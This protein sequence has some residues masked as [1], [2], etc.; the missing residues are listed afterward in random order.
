MTRG[1]FW[2]RRD[3][4]VADNP[5]L[6]KA[7]ADCD[8]LLLLYID[9][10][11]VESRW[12]E[13]AASRWWLQS[14]LTSLAMELHRRGTRL[15]FRRGAAPEILSQ[16]VGWMDAG[17]VYWN[18]LYEP[19]ALRTEKAVIDDLRR[20]GCG[21]VSG[22]ANLLTTPES[23]GKSD[24]TPYRVFSPFWRARQRAGFDL[25]ECTAPARLPPAPNVTGDPI[26]VQPPGRWSEKFKAYWEPGEASAR[27]RLQRFINGELGG[28]PNSRDRPA[29][30]GTSRLSPHL[31][32]GEIGPRQILSAVTAWAAETGRDAAAET[33]IRQLGWREF[34]HHLLCHF[35]QTP[36]RPLDQRFEHFRWNDD[37]L[38]SLLAWQ[39]AETGFPIIDA[40]LRELW[41]TG[42]MHN[43]VRLIA[44]SFLTK[45]LL[46]PWQEGARWFWDTLLD[47]DL[48]NNTLGWQW[49]AGSGADAA[50]WFRIF[51][52]VLQAER[53]DPEG[54]YV[55]RWLP[56]LQSLQGRKIHQP[57]RSD[58]PPADYPPPMVDLKAT[59]ERALLRYRQL[60]KRGRP[61]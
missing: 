22:D 35:P 46:V 54:G 38:E 44:A 50:P 56:E 12:P 39:R 55:R 20:L 14:S 45:N 41:E 52:P 58:R 8:E 26:D 48:A 4:R 3:L 29:R 23:S 17:W 43:R 6:A 34:A 31:H 30:T 1:I 11:A 15:V 42:W 36:D 16:L 32:F 49:V 10:P 7:A 25:G 53:F 13:G 33:F 60:P 40:G 47:A 27:R 59:R 21:L 2:F 9:E 28:Y 19:A 51:N 37:Y 5:L 18:R 57:W 61:R 24:G